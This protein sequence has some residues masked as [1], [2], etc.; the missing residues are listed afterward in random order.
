MEF[1]VMHRGN[2][3]QSTFKKMEN[4]HWDTDSVGLTA[5]YWSSPSALFSELFAERV[6]EL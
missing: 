4:A 1:L 5:E 6:E 3:R 2:V